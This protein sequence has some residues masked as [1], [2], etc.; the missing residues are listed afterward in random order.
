MALHLERRLKNNRFMPRQDAQA[1]VT[2]VEK[3]EF[4][5]MLATAIVRAKS[6][7][8]E[9][10]ELRDL[11]DQGST[12]SFISE[13]VAQRLKLKRMRNSTV[14]TGIGAGKTESIH[15]SVNICIKPKYTSVFETSV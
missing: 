1:H 3:D 12:I 4:D 15:G 6:R 11:I 9:Y 5:V 10:L 13:E 2:N 14:V 8:G 7:D